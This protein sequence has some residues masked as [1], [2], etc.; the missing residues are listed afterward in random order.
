M[1][2]K[3]HEEHTVDGQIEVRKNIDRAINSSPRLRKKKEQVVIG[4][5]K[6][7][8]EKFFDICPRGL[9]E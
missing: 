5:I 8:F 9:E 2:K 4:K 7:F 6:S 3:Y 1:V